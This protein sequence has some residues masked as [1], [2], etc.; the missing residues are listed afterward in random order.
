MHNHNCKNKCKKNYN[1]KN[2]YKLKNNYD[3]V[4]LKIQK[5][6]P[7]NVI[8]N[9]PVNYVVTVTNI[10]T[11]NVRNIII[12]DVYGSP[13]LAHIPVPNVS[14]GV[15]IND[16]VLSLNSGSFNWLIPIL[17]PNAIAT[18]TFTIEP[19]VPGQILNYV[20][21]ISYNEIRK[22]L[23]FLNNESRIFTTVLASP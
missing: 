1:C 4:D 16:G 2:E 3:F 5:T 19:T 6:G 11:I 8:I 22:D 15:I 23:S 12:R 18:L 13:T 14:T 20:V 9:K 21:I 10:S 7:T 17:A